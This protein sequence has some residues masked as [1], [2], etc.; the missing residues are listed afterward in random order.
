MNLLHLLLFKG[1]RKVGFGLYL[2][3]VANVYLWM[4]LIS[5]GEWMN[6]VLLVSCLVGGGTAFDRYIESKKPGIPPAVPPQ[7]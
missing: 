3:I 1:S 5:S 4:K 6:C 2:F 7:A